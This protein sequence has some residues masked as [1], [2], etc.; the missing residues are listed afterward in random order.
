MSTKSIHHFC[1]NNSVIRKEINKVDLLLVL[2]LVPCLFPSWWPSKVIAMPMSLFNICFHPWV[3]GPEGRARNGDW[4]V[5]DTCNPYS[6]NR[7]P[8]EKKA[9][10]LLYLH[11][12]WSSRSHQDWPCFVFFSD[13]SKMTEYSLNPETEL[14]GLHWWFFSRT[15]WGQQSRHLINAFIFLG[16]WDR[17]VASRAAFSNSFT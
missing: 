12:C 10:Q 8:K 6:W 2:T 7:Q 13:V 1:E 17:R 9:D 5:L 3:A 16:R 4:N 11:I 14:L 15:T